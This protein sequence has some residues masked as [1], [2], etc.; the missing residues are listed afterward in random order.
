MQVRVKQL[1]ALKN[2][3]P[4]NNDS[5]S[6]LFSLMEFERRLVQIQSAAQE[7]ANFFAVS[8]KEEDQVTVNGSSLQALIELCSSGFVSEF[9]IESFLQGCGVNDG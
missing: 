3:D 9:T 5:K 2:Y 7:L 1:R 8:I 4:K 6:Q